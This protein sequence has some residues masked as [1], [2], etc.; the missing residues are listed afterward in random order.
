MSC[1]PGSKLRRDDV[2]AMG[3]DLDDGEAGGVPA[4]AEG[5]DEQDAGDEA[6]AVDYG[7]LLLVL[8]QVLLRR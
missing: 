3:F 6:L 7:E 8:Q 5:F 1:R 4:A 2:A